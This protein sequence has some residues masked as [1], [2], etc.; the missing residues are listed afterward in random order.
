MILIRHPFFLLLLFYGTAMNALADQKISTE[1]RSLEFKNKIKPFLT[2]YCYDCHA[3]G[4]AKGQ[5]SLDDPNKGAHHLNNRELWLQIW[6]YLRSDLMPPAKNDQ[7]ETAEKNEI[8]HWIESNIFLIDHDNPDPGRVTMR[9][10]NRVEYAHTIQDLFGVEFNVTD[11]FPPDDTGYGFDT[12]GDVLTISPLLMEKYISAAEQIM[13]KAIPEEVG[14]PQPLSIEPHEFRQEGNNAKTA[15]F[16][17]AGIKHTVGMDWK[18]SNKGVHRLKVNY[19]ITARASAQ[20]YKS[21]LQVLINGKKHESQ[22]ISLS[23]SK[24]GTISIDLNL[25]AN[26]HR[27]EFAMIPNNGDTNNNVSLAVKVLKVEMVG[28]PGSINWESYPQSYRLIF[29][30]GPPPKDSTK[31]ELYTKRLLNRIASRAYRRPVN[32]DTLEKLIALAK[33]KESADGSYEAG[34]RF[35]LTAIISSPSFL[36]R[37]EESFRDNNKE[38]TIDEYSLASRLSYFL[39]SSTPDAPLLR[40]AAQGKLRD[41]LKNTFD[42]MLKDPK[43]ER[44]IENFVGQ[45]LQTRDVENKFFD[46]PQIL[47][48]DDGNKARQ[49]F[50]LYTR[51]DM[52]KE[53]ELFFSHIL[54]ENRPAIELITADYSFINDRLAKFYG[55]NEFKSNEFQKVSF[56]GNSRPGG[57]LTQGSFLIVTSNPT[58]TSPVK[59]G[60]FVI[61]NLLGVPNSAAPPSVPELEESRKKIGEGATMRQL[62]ELHR[63]KPLC[64]SCH[65]RMDP[66]GLALEDYNAIGQRLENQGNEIVDTSGVLVTG[67]KFNDVSELKKIIAGPRKKDFHRC[68]TEKLFTYSLGRGVEYYDTPS[69]NKIINEAENQGGGLKDFVYALIE[70]VPFQKR[71]VESEN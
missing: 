69:I 66:I 17:R 24:N 48:I 68:L 21:T 39:W 52:K 42:R 9:R 30:A 50:N 5:V 3:E 19:E 55:I 61:D 13:R 28:P 56:K 59:R 70:S 67:E 7:P 44:F 34:I 8:I 37:G 23:K 32:Q 33:A 49:I 51:Q 36:L 31:R 53:T 29:S 14:R 18:A 43:S 41:D 16:M 22:E 38:Q 6:E 20:D 25:S 4:S 62:M 12:I 35:A 45:W 40:L 10:L 15:R 46:T 64:K 57:I 2:S 1:D 54:N 58:R 63:S 11:N 65:A 71:R 47:G 26:T 27:I 60:L